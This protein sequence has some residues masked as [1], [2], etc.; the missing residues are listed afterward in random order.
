M[1]GDAEIRKGLLAQLRPGAF[2]A[3]CG[4]QSVSRADTVHFEVLDTDWSGGGAYIGD[5]AELAEILY[6][7]G[8]SEQ[9]WDILKRYFWMGK[10][11]VYYPQ[12]AFADRPAVPA[13]KRANCNSGLAHAQAILYGLAGFDPQPDGSLWLDPHPPKNGRIALKG[14]RAHGHT[15]DVEFSDGTCRVVCDGTEIYHGEPKRLCI[16]KPSGSASP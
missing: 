5:G 7:V 14:Y 6:H 15:V 10:R 11:L 9:A 13:Q 12:E 3:D 1:G 4:V 2:L 16:G 8:E